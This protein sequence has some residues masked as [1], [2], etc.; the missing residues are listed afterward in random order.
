MRRLDPITTNNGSGAAAAPR[1]SPYI[2]HVDE[3]G[4]LRRLYA[5][6]RVLVAGATGFLGANC[7]YALDRLDADVTIVTRSPRGALPGFAGTVV[8]GD[9]IH[10]DV[11]DAVVHDQDIV[12]D[13]LGYPRL[14]PSA[15]EPVGDLEAEL[16]PHINLFLACAHAQPRPTLVHCSS[17]L[18]YGAPRYLPVDE[19]H[20]TIP[21]S[22]Y[23]VHKLAMEHYLETLEQTHS[24]RRIVVRLSSPFGPNG[25]R[26]EPGRFGVLNQFM[27]RAVLNKPITIFGTGE[28]M[29]DYIFIDDVVRAFLL[30]G[31]SE[32]CVGETFNLG[33]EKG[34][35]LRDAAYTIARLAGGSPVRHEP[36]P[37]EARAVETGSYC[38][39]LRKIRSCIPLGDTT[40]FQEGAQ[41]TLAWLR[42]V[43]TPDASAAPPLS[44]SP[45]LL[46][47]PQTV[48]RTS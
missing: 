48:A 2:P 43:I 27:V 23:A 47:D 7:V 26:G 12:F 29:R 44:T 33:G 46:R 42:S 16:R 22:I 3:D 17:R 28:Q 32:R 4:E 39:D 18:V 31:A 24:L 11:A 1:F 30:L 37:N 41:R 10:R 40:S 25:G 13:F 5:G 9:L 36:W 15:T 34:V 45:R 38:T 21:R 35:R 20:P 8:Q 19:Q 6:R 14:T